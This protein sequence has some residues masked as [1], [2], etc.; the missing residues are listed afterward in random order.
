MVIGRRG[1]EGGKGEYSKKKDS[2]LSMSPSFQRRRGWKVETLAWE[3]E[4]QASRSDPG[5][6]SCAFHPSVALGDGL[7]RQL[8]VITEDVCPRDLPVA[9]SIAILPK[10]NPV[11]FRTTRR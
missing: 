6:W 5:F 9:F 11:A 10:K 1:T 3:I 4:A 7:G 2:G 8:L